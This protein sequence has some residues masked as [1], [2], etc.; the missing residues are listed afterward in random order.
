M[1]VSTTTTKKAV[2]LCLGLLVSVACGV[3][4][5]LPRSGNSPSS[6]TLNTKPN[7]AF[8][9]RNGTAAY[10]KAMAKYAHLVDHGVD[11]ASNPCKSLPPKSTKSLRLPDLFQ[12]PTRGCSH[13]LRRGR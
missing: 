9:G 2:G 6:F 5:I 13:R 7:P 8:K 11:K 4:S 3:P 1:R 12:F 10:L